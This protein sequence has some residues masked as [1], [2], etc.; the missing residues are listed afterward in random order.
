MKVPILDVANRY[1]A[2]DEI[3]AI[4]VVLITKDG[5]VIHDGIASTDYHYHLLV[6]ATMGSSSFLRDRFMAQQGLK[7]VG[8]D[9]PGDDEETDA[10]RTR[11]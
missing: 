7:A 9:V 5:I 2:A 6:S 8:Q 1:Q 4:A 10:A 3:E 11:N